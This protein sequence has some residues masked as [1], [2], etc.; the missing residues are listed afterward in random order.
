MRKVFAASICFLAS[1]GTPANIESNCT[2]NGFGQVSCEF[3]NTG[4]RDGSACVKLVLTPAPNAVS[5][6]SLESRPICSGIVRTHDVV[7]R[8]TNGGFSQNPADY[9]RPSYGSTDWTTYCSMEVQP[10]PD[11]D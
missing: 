10:T 6:G 4:G 9:C 8:D 7:Q 2:T 5:T 1:C 3:H 11:E